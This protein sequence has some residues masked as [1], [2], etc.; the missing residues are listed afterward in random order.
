[1]TPK[2]GWVCQR[3]LKIPQFAGTGIILVEGL[4]KAAA[5]R[6]DDARRK[7]TGDTDQ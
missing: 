5:R 6:L 1:M 7:V 4:N 2:A 3:R